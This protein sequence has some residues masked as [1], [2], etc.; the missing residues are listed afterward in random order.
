MA[1]KKHSDTKQ[2][3]LGAVITLAVWAL[4]VFSAG[5]MPFLVDYIY[6]PTESRLITLV[7]PL[8]LIV[9]SVVFAVICKRK[10]KDALF[11]G[12]YLFLIIPSASFLFL[13]VN[14]YL[15]LNIENYISFV[16]LLLMLPAAPV[17]SAFDAFFSAFYGNVRPAGF[18]DAHIVFGAVLIAACVLPPVIYKLVKSKHPSVQ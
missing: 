15:N 8:L 2:F 7:F 5:R 11:F 9:Y 12:S 10:D 14:Q 17:L 4:G 18:S 3:F 13:W 1:N 6:L 16:L